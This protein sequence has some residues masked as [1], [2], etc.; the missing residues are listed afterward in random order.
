MSQQV[1]PPGS[2]PD[3]TPGSSPDS[4]PEAHTAPTPGAGTGA[5]QPRGPH[6]SSQRAKV[7]R[8]VLVVGA[9]VAAAVV[10][11]HSA[12]LIVVLAIVAMIML[13]EAGHFATAK[14]AGMKVTEYFL[15]FG[16][17]LWSVRRGETEYGIKAIPA[18][19]YVK[20][21]GMTNLEAVPEADEPRTYR[22]APFWRRFSVAVAGSTVHFLLAFLMLWSI[23]ALVGTDN[24]PQ[25]V[26]AALSGQAHGKSPAQVAG[27]RAGD[28]LI[29]VD[30]NKV[31]SQDALDSY[32]QAHAGV[33]LAVVVNRG[34]HDLTLH[35][36]PE[37]ASRLT[38]KPTPGVVAPK[39]GSEGV[40]GVETG[41][42]MGPPAVRSN[43]ISAISQA[44]RQFWY[45]TSTS[46]IG[47]GDVFSAHGLAS[48][49]GQVVGTTKTPKSAAAATKDSGR[50]VSL[51]GATR[52]AA[53]A[54]HAG[55]GDLLLVLVDINIF[56]GLANMFPLLPL[57]GGHVVIAVYERL[58]SWRGRHYHADVAKLLPLTYAMFLFLIVLGA[59]AFYLDIAHPLPNLF[60]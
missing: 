37:P 51:I 9:L 43:P 33:P 27:F 40:I 45:V 29:S 54:A 17:R 28:Q 8:L 1:L 4:T 6:H 25:V 41:V 42:Q 23:F 11:G 53:Q 47:I 16:P 60:Q 57:D 31:T 32:I 2:S 49:V 12:L 52:I 38:I 13:H 10:T 56:I 30:G 19:G 50:I 20:I 58:R 3:S 36:T 5:D 14:W 44:G 34:G 21:I 22:Q 24:T 26:V 55:T 18:G 35:V 48:Y 39:P 7:V 59:S 46:V 15:G